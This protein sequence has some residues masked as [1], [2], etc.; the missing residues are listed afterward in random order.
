MDGA[1]NGRDWPANLWNMSTGSSAY[2]E[3]VKGAIDAAIARD[4]AANP[5][6][7]D[8]PSSIILAGHSQGGIIAANLA[9]DPN[10][11]ASHDIRGIVAAGAPVECAEV[12]ADV[13]VLSFQHGDTETASYFGLVP[14]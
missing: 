1:Q 9:S 11:A 8:A 7:G 3:A 5:T 4:Q 10:F 2:T 6:A 13:P 14:Y 12:P